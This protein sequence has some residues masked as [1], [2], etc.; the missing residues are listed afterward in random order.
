M[1]VDHAIISYEPA[2]NFP[3]IETFY[4]SVGYFGLIVPSSVVI[5]ARHGDAIVGAARIAKENDILVLRGMMIAPSHQRRGLGTRMLRELDK[6][7][8]HS[9]CFCLPHGSLQSFYGQ[10]GFARIADDLSPSHLWERL[11]AGHIKYPQL[12]IMRRPENL[13]K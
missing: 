5:A 10:I 3:A 6:H 1:I 13:T 8:G 7:I 11:K 2:N 12:V 4:A 9:E